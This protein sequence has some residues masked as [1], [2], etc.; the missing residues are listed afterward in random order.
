[1]DN[2]HH[3]HQVTIPWRVSVCSAWVFLIASLFIYTMKEVTM[4]VDGCDPGIEGDENGDKPQDLPCLL[5]EGLV[6][7]GR[8]LQERSSQFK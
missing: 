8:L 6:Q 4:D 3:L 2:Q 5:L 7:E 1:M